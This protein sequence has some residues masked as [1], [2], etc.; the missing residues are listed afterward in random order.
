VFDEV[1]PN[2]RRAG[3]DMSTGAFSPNRSFVFDTAPLTARQ[4]PCLRSARNQ[5]GSHTQPV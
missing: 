4:H 3:L 2:F 5:A 1:G